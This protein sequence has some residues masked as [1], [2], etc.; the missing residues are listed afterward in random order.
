[1]KPTLEAM[2]EALVRLAEH[3]TGQRR[4]KVFYL[5]PDDWADFMATDPPTV[6]TTFRNE[7]QD[8][9]SFDGVPV[10]Q[11]FNVPPRQSRLYDNTGT[12][13]LIRP[14]PPREGKFPGPRF[15]DRADIPA[16]EV[17]DALDKLSRTRAL[18]DHES[19]ALEAAM[20]G[21]CIL[22]KRDAARLGIKRKG[23]G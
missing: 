11:S 9:P 7:P 13:R 2:A 22:T 4:P 1:M 19:L 8:A 3:W 14:D 16:G 12:G 10:R 23:H 6:M 18:T 15:P 20:K 21:R 17:L 5:G